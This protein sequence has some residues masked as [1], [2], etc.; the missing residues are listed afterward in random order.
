M[1]TGMAEE[2][3]ITEFTIPADVAFRVLDVLRLAWIFALKDSHPEELPE[4]F[5]PYKWTGEIEWA[6][7]SSEAFHE[8]LCA[9]MQSGEGG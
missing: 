3:Q 6:E 9:M 1:G 2:A 5:K 7:E 4:D 8:M